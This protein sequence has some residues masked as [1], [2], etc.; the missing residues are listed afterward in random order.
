MST[1]SA[2]D[3]HKET[4]PSQAGAGRQ[5][6]AAHDGGR[7][8]KTKREIAACVRGMPAHQQKDTVQAV[9]DALHDEARRE[10]AP[11]LA[12]QMDASQKKKTA[13][14]LMAD[15]PAEDKQE[16]AP[17]LIQDM[18]AA[19]KKRTATEVMAGMP[20]GDKQDL[21][22]VLTSGMNTD[23]KKNT[24]TQLA[25]A[26]PAAD[27]Q[28]VVESVLG[29]P[30]TRTR[31]AIWLAVVYTLV[32]VIFVFGGISFVLILLKKGS[33]E[34]PLTLATTALGAV[35]GLVASN[36]RRNG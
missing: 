9:F 23:Q 20:A 36:S 7:P 18:D 32:G 13:A 4:R 28:D 30:D 5:H 34:V 17:A 22:G 16:L 24:L 21:T 11:A 15:L 26:V 33:A 14:R 35:I 31:N 27:R 3:R 12:Q 25:M 8:G 1:M 19:R 10:V 2:A 29:P 6:A